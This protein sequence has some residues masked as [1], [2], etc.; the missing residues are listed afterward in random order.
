MTTIKVDIIKKKNQEPPT[1]IYIYIYISQQYLRGKKSKR[2][3]DG[4]DITILYILY[5]HFTIK[6][7]MH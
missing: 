3:L 1:P 5:M 4:S 2:N 7:Q 6:Q